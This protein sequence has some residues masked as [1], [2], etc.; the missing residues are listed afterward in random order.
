MALCEYYEYFF[1]LRKDVFNAIW[2]G[3]LGG[4]LLAQELAIDI[5]SD[6]AMQ[7]REHTHT[8]NFTNQSNS[9]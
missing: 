3:G 2:C 9:K 8:M 6:I 5:A 4:G 7:M 1:F